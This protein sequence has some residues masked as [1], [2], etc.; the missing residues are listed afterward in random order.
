VRSIVLLLLVCSGCFG[1]LEGSKAL[2]GDD[3]IG[4]GSG[5]PNS[6]C[7]QKSDCVPAA[8]TC[9][10]CPTFATN[11]KDPNVLACAGVECPIDT[12]CPGNVEADCLD[13]QCVLTCAPTA[14]ATETCPAGF[15][16]DANGCLT[17]SCAMSPGAGG[18]V[19][20]RDCVATR[21]DC[22]GCQ[23][24]GTDTAVLASDASKFDTMLGCPQ[25]PQCPGINTCTAGDTP[26]CVGGGCELLS[27]PP[28]PNACGRPD[29]PSCAAGEVC[30][31]NASDPANLYGVGVC[32]PQ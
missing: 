21:A 10:E 8:T 16:T 31:V 9:C 23:N 4:S 30:T 24:G 13:N 26:R 7:F 15:A 20:D 32:V 25:Q 28:P 3:G 17:C 19:G 22:C 6:G 11:A 1:G 29:L 14:C 5:P 12:V 18:C 27:V 2:G